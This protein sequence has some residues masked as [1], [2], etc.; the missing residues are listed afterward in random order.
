MFK[1]VKTWKLE[2]LVVLDCIRLR[3]IVAKGKEED[4]KKGGELELPK[5]TTL[6]FSKLPKL[7]SFY[8]GVNGLSCPLLNELSIE[9]CGNLELFREETVD[10][11]SGKETILF[12]EVVINNL[13]S[14]Q[15]EWQHAKSSTR[16]RRDNLE[17]LR[18][19]RLKDVIYSFLH[20]N[21]NLKS[22]W[23]KDCSFQ[24]LMPLDRPANFKSLGV[25][26][27]LKSLKLTNL[28]WLKEI[29][30]EHIRSSHNERKMND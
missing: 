6:N 12:P 9:L 10:A 2:Y 30:F 18:L 24:V 21:P 7:K 22:L 26:P 14:M 5:L 4:I 27:K 3:E 28:I 29:G 16:Y 1:I 19:S 13:K 25:V 23:L 20:S 17:E 15:I 11:S 8:P